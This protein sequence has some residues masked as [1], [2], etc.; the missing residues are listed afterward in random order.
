MKKALISPSEHVHDVEN[1]VIKNN[2][3]GVRVLQ[4][5]DETFPVNLPQY[6]IDCDDTIKPDQ[7]CYNETFKTFYVF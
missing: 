5:V 6:W 3:V 1:N 4:V 7:H 2:F